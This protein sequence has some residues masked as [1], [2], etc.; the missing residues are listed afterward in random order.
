MKT[1]RGAALL[2]AL[3]KTPPE[4]SSDILDRGIIMTG[5]GSLLRG[6]DQRLRRE[7]RLPVNLAEDPMTAVV[8]GVGKVLDE[9]DRYRRMLNLKV[10]R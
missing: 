1:I 6:L 10:R 9:L 8:R 7:T 2:L 3:E 5:G 4:L